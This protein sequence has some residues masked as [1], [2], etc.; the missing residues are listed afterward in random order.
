MTIN[1]VVI[2]KDGF[3]IEVYEDGEEAQVKIEGKD[4][5]Y[6]LKHAVSID[7]GVT[8]GD[9]V[10][11]VNACS[12]LEEFIGLY[13]HCNIKEHNKFILNIPTEEVT[14]IEWIEVSWSCRYWRDELEFWIDCYGV[15]KIGTRDDGE[16]E[17]FAIDLTPSNKLAK[18]PVKIETEFDMSFISNDKI[19]G[20]GIVIDKKTSYLK[21]K[22]FISFLDLLDALYEEISF[23]GSE[24]NKEEIFEEL[25]ET[26]ENMKLDL[27][28]GQILPYK[29]VDGVKIYLS[30]Q[31][32]GVFNLPTNEE[33]RDQQIAESSVP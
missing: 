12:E 3:Y 19:I 22:R 25:K 26:S 8:F 4:C 1:R 10:K 18:L 33:D 5:I 2:K 27:D 30:D 23:F 11:H 6:A 15:G 14:D 31:V 24:S 7:D 13:N 21:A 28:N 29:I 16:R 17:H 32:R 20:E 9:I